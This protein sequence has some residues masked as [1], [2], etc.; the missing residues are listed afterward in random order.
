MPA[1]LKGFLS[2]YLSRSLSI[3]RLLSPPSTT[4]TKRDIQSSTVYTQFDVTEKH[5][6]SSLSLKRQ[7]G[8]QKKALFFVCFVGT[9]RAAAG[10]VVP[11]SFFVH[12]CTSC[13]LGSRVLVSGSWSW[14]GGGGG[15]GW[16]RGGE[17]GN[18]GCVC[19]CVVT[20][21]SHVSS[22]PSV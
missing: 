20:F 4:W 1:P 9:M 16:G 19:V 11:F 14:G 17:E 3:S 12:D 22:L 7:V 10:S 2:L 15:S 5:D 21:Q 18:S 8:G 6:S 13:F